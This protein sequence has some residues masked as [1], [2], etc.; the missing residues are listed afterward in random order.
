MSHPTSLD[1]WIFGRQPRP[2]ARVRLFCFPYAGGGASIYRGWQALLPEAIEVCPVQLP[3]RENR[4]K[5]APYTRVEPLVEALVPALAPLMDRP[6]AL[7]GHSMGALIAFELARAL[8]RANA[9][10]PI[11][12]FAVALPA[13]HL[14]WPARHDLP[15][16]ELL[17]LI[18]RYSATPEAV[19]QDEELLDRHILPLLRAD[20]AITDAY[21]HTN[22][23]PLALPFSVFGGAQDA[24][25]PAEALPEWAAHSTYPLAQRM[26][27]GGHFF[28]AADREAVARAISEALR[29][30]SVAQEL[31]R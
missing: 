16:E 2:E 25:V 23:P 15:R 11:H 10:L 13:P 30:A 3:G 8:R 21:A 26:F 22:E 5:E 27:E 19:L 6:F 24:V 12:L 1:A 17:M 20:F 31:P 28:P 9:P 7:F 29:E 18:R 14:R 4:I